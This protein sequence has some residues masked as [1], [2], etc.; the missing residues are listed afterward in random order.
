MKKRI[1]KLDERGYA[2]L[3][4]FVSL[5][6]LVL[7]LGSMACA[8]VWG[9]KMY[10]YEMADWA[11]QEE[12]RTVMERVTGHLQTAY[13]LELS[14]EE[15]NQGNVR[16]FPAVYGPEDMQQQYPFCRGWYLQL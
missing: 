7:L 3:Q 8:L 11:L 2:L 6:I 13:R 9:A 1:G 15:W 10:L 5:P 4:V 16:I 14:G 12:M